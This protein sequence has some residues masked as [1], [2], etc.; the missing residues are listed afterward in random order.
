MR[1]CR[2]VSPFWER[3]APSSKCVRKQAAHETDRARGTW[4]EQSA[5]F[6][7][8]QWIPSSAKHRGGI[9]ADYRA[10]LKRRYYAFPG[11]DGCAPRDRSDYDFTLGILTSHGWAAPA[12]C[13]SVTQG[14]IR[15]QARQQGLPT[16]SLRRQ[17]ASTIRSRRAL[18]RWRISK[19]F[20][21]H[22]GEDFHL[23]DGVRTM[24][25]QDEH[26][27]GRDRITGHDG[28]ECA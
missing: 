22:L 4:T 1:A 12:C 27:G 5:S 3:G 9:W 17:V 11:T 26:T 20:D 13:R 28:H 15:K 18:V 6:R 10:P 23:S 2:S 25:P 19:L 8:R 24:R 16:L 21:E 14:V 7:Q